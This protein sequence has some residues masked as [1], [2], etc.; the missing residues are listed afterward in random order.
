MIDDGVGLLELAESSLHESEED[1]LFTD[2]GNEGGG[3][4]TISIK[5]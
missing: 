3:N 2:D 4:D 5:Y 1:M